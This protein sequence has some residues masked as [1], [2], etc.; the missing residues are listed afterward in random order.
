MANWNYYAYT[1]PI[2]KSKYCPNLS[3]A[4]AIQQIL[5]KDWDL[6]VAIFDEAGS[7]KLGGGGYWIDYSFSEGG[8]Y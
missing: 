6:F 8:S 2:R 7:G 4:Q 3:T 1:S 5:A